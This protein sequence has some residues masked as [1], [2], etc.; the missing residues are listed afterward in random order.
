VPLRCLDIA[1]E[2]WR[3]PAWAAN[4]DIGYWIASDA[5]VLAAV[6]AAWFAARP[7]A[8]VIALAAAAATAWEYWGDWNGIEPAA[9]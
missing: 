3:L 6:T 9:C 8:M 2:A 5:L 7:V 4:P 1:V